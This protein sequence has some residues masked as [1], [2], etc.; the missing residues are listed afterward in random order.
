MELANIKNLS[1]EQL[2]TTLAG[3]GI[4]GYRYTQIVKWLYQFD[5]ADFNAMTNLSKALRERLIAM[6]TIERWVPK[7][8]QE[9]S[10]GTRKFLYE[11]SDGQTLE[12]VLIP[13][14]DRMTLCIST[15][16]GCAMGCAFCLTSTLGLMRNLTLFEIIEQIMASVR[17][18]SPE[19]KI[20]NL[21]FMGMGEPFHNYATVI[22]ALKIIIDRNALSI[23]KRRVTVSTCG[24][25]PQIEQF[26]HD[27][28]V[29]L[30]VSLTG[31][32]DV[33]RDQLIPMNRKYNLK[34]LM[35]ACKKYSQISG[36]PVTFEYTLLAG[37]NDFLADAERL[38]KL[39]K[40]VLA[41]VNL[42]PFNAFAES[43]FERTSDE[44]T[45]R[46]QNVLYQHD[47]Q[48]NVRQSRGRDI[49]GACGQLKAAMEPKAT[50]VQK[51]LHALERLTEAPATPH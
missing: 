2:Q 19:Q 45:Y 8:V 18:L 4:E 5:V 46:F 42:I 39:L 24:L 17:Q 26:A 36:Y 38:V 30:A 34:R 33:M 44:Q 43:G 11:L 6:F 1:L 15:Q 13:K 9:S 37:V 20:T 23:G 40:G 22:N 29:K 7:I 14:A 31:T 48:T 25:V 51:Q 10:D 28:D 16:V 3:W 49:L 12:S 35:Q 32:T 41:K 50:F 21:V 47:I 27:S